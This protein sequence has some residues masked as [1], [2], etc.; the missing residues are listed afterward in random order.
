MTIRQKLI[1]GTSG[2]LISIS[3]LFTILVEYKVSG[4]MQRQFEIKGIAMV[5]NLSA[6]A[7]AGVIFNDPEVQQ[8]AIT[9]V[10]A[11][12]VGR[13][14]TYVA[15]QDAKKQVLSETGDSG[16]AREHQPNYDSQLNEPI[17][18]KFSYRG[19]DYLDL[20]MPIISARDGMKTFGYARIVF[21]YAEQ[22]RIGRELQQWI[23][24]AT[25][26]LLIIC[27]VVAYFFAQRLVTPVE[28]TA[29]IVRLMAEGDLSKR[30]TIK[31]HD[32]VGVLA[33]SI[34]RLAEN[35]Q[36]SMNSL[37]GKDRIEELMQSEKHAK[38]RLQ[39]K[40]EE[41]VQFTEKIGRGDLT[42]VIHAQGDD[43][44]AILSRHLNQMI[45]SLKSITG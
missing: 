20:Y 1:A 19:Y 26:L 22:N 24:G 43:E 10:K 32:E 15:L 39:E 6:F 8:T 17:P 35:L 16:T 29:Q 11:G 42:A 3:A 18:E 25:G 2:L 9:G 28:H 40:V 23:L 38:E 4:A 27:V 7:L 30:I 37:I 12:S 41:F 33:E 44:L 45:D 31:S 34:N 14:V 13:D 21:S 5:K 36:A